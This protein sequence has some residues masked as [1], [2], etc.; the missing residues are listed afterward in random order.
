M[1]DH[2]PLIIV[3]EFARKWK[4]WTITA[5]NLRLID[6]EYT[7]AP[8]YGYR[9]MTARL[10]VRGY[11]VNRERSSRLMC[12]MGLLAIY[13]GPRTSIS[14]RQHRKYPYLLRGLEITHPNQAWAADITCVQ[15]VHVYSRP[16]GCNRIARLVAAS[17]HYCRLLAETL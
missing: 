1:Q 4:V 8:S 11:Y 5:S 10:E 7:R 15:C 14:A 13:P 6:E 16:R 3:R 12:K 2:H 17:I 9:K